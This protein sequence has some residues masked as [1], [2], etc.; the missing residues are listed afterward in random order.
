MGVYKRVGVWWIGFTTPEGRR[1]LESSGASDRQAAEQVYERRRT[2]VWRVELLGAKPKRQ[3]EEA[4]VQWVK[5]KGHKASLEKDKE[6]FRWADRWLRGRA[7]TEINRDLLFRMAEAKAD[8]S[9]ESTANRYMAL[10]RAVLRRACE[11]WE[12]V[13]RVPK[14]PMYT[15]RKKRIR[16]ITREEADRL[17]SF[18][19]PHQAAMA[20]FALATGLRQRNVC[21]LKW[22]AVDRER[23][24]AWIHPDQSK[25]RRAIAV[26]L[27]ADAL[28]VLR[29]QQGGHPEWV[30]AYDGQAVWQVN[31]KS[32]RRAVKLAGLT[33][34][35]W[36]DLR[37]TWASWHVQAGTPLN[38]LQEMGGWSSFEMV[39]RYAHLSAAHLLPHAERI[40][41]AASERVEKGVANFATNLLHP[42]HPKVVQLR[43]CLN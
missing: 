7:L 30:F 17:I 26:P 38:V 16:W 6:I 11:V 1:V 4:V 19:P 32:W 18:L 29:Q 27:N 24:F 39:L 25:T 9:N 35:R 13:E 33:D 22:A 14:V 23:S 2:E 10:I 5:E 8:E 20:R 31:T 12:W 21:R 34:F 40:V 36:H 43:K 28:E 3:W 42:A 37:H 41:V 15:I